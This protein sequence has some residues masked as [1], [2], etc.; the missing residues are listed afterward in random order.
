MENNINI[1]I[2]GGYIDHKELLI[3]P[4]EANNLKPNEV[5]L[6]CTGSQGEPL[7]AL[8][9]IAD[10]THKKIKIIPGDTIV[11]SSSAIPGNQEGI[12]RTINIF[13]IL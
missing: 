13:N 5:T 3:S 1:S 8:S 11:F 4:E 6:L 2:N 7:A 10:G 9:R 12:N